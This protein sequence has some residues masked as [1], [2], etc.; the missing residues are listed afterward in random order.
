MSHESALGKVG[1]FGAWAA[2]V[3][4]GIDADAPAGREEAYDLDVLGF[5][6]A[7]KV[8]HDL[9]DAVLMEVAVVAEGEEV[10]LQALRLHHALAGDV[11]DL[12]LGKVGLA[13][14]GA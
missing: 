4:I 1:V 9:V 6:Q 10:E 14:D 11:E 5:H 7:H 13:R 12:D 8:F 3:G 2:V